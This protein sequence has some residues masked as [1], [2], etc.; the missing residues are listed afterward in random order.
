MLDLFLA[1]AAVVAAPAKPSPPS[2]A[3]IS[4]ATQPALDPER[5]ALGRQ[6]VLAFLPPGSIQKM[7]SSMTNAR[8]GMMDQ[9]MHATPKDFGAKD[10]K[11]SNK[12]LG[13]LV[14]ERDPYFEQRMEITNRVMMEEMGKVMAGF[15]PEL[16]EAMARMYARRFNKTELTDLAAFLR[17]PSGS[18]FASQL[19]LMMSDPEYQ[20]AMKKLTPKIMLAMPQIMEKVKKATA[21][22]PSPKGE[23]ER[24]PASVPTT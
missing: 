12:T 17:T 22:L 21:G 1:G 9:V 8:S 19:M 24:K 7:M 4:S 18:S 14:R 2:V 5:L 11:D 23:D 16:R 10:A 3:A 6:I 13:E 20:E 15:E